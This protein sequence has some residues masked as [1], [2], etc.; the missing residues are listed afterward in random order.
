MK[1]RA[2]PIS[3]LLL[4]TLFAFILQ[5]YHPGAEDDGVY[6]SAI[7]RDLDPS[8][9]PYNATFFTLQLQATLFDK[10][11]A[12][13]V[14]FTHIPVAYACLLLQLA[15]IGLLL[16]GCWRILDF[17]FASFRAKLA[18][19]LSVA[20]LLTLSVAGT[21][22]YISDEHLH[23]RIVATDAILFSL[24]ALQ[25]GKPRRAVLLLIVAMLFHPIMGVLGVSFCVL[26]VC[27]RRAVR[28]NEQAGVS[29]SFRA[30][31]LPGAWLFSPATPA[32][33]QALLQHSY[34]TLGAWHWYE[35]LGAVAPPALLWLLAR[36]GRRR[37]NEPFFQLALA[38]AV[39]SVVQLV[40]AFAMLLPPA[41]V[42]LTPLQP[43]RYLHLT[44]L[45]MALLA[46]AALGEY[47]LGTRPLRWLLVFLPLAAVNGYTQRTR[48]PATSNLELPWVAPHNSWLQT[49]AWVRLN[50]PKD[51]VFAL[52]PNY[53][54]LP[55]DDNHS[56]RALAERS[57]LADDRKDAAVV[58]QVPRLAQT[59]V[60]QHAEQ[61]NWPSWTQDDFARLARTTPVRWVIVQLPQAK[62][63]A[64]PYTNAELSVCR[65]P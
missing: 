40:I 39:F 52:D 48:Y 64:C 9:Y 4:V 20:S 54:A 61:K 58:T 11:V 43:M 29:S 38:V 47:V 35:W 18:G 60:T 50:T 51:A 26:Y 16:A 22:L 25:R 36:L 6:L 53:L 42:R 27:T 41:F 12:G 33:R 37:G 32:W 17:C 31:A 49:F 7:K 1:R 46:G 8:L 56:F 19:V 62:G 34:Y 5:G 30:A 28:G 10:A 14:R 59:W 13:F 65:I 15:A 24:A 3:V 21:A 55:G 57:A 63:L 44:F 2:L 23:P 45:L